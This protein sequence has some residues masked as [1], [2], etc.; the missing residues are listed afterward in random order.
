MNALRQI[1]R[2]YRWGRPASLPSDHPG[3]S[4]KSEATF[5]TAWARTLPFRVVRHVVQ[6]MIFAPVLKYVASPI[7]HGVSNLDLIAPPAVFAANHASHLDTAVIVNSLPM[8][9]RRKVAVGAAADHFFSSTLRGLTAAFLI[10]AFPV[11]RRRASAVSARLAVKLLGDGFSLILFPEGGRSPDGWPQEL[12]PGAAFA[13]IKARCPLVP[14]WIEGTEHL[15]PK[16]GGIH[17]GEIGVFFGRP[18]L[19]MPDEGPRELNQRLQSA[20]N[21]LATEAQSDWWTSLRLLA[22]GADVAADSPVPQAGAATWRRRWT[23]G[24]APGRTKSLW[25]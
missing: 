11:E 24:A 2:G 1:A 7:A 6:E 17:R 22:P 14:V 9:W 12:K 25:P 15:M 5:E 3:K 16:A 4:V 20:L 23:R 19:E 13:A 21:A 8:A 10:N 18:L